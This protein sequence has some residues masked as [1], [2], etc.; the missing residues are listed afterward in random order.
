MAI[1]EIPTNFR[2]YYKSMK[3][4]IG[5]KYEKA[6]DDYEKGLV[7]EKALYDDIKLK[8]ETYKTVYKLDLTQIPEFVENKYIDGTFYDSAKELFLNRK[9][10]YIATNPAY[11]IYKLA[12]KQKELH[13]LKHQIEVYEKML[14]VTLDQ[15]Q[16]ILQAF[17][18]EVHKKLI[19]DGYGYVTGQSIE[20]GKDVSDNTVKITLS[21]KSN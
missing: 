4:A 16:K 21:Q 8:A 13:E 12:R 2:V 10:A 15:Y 18:N 17:Y 11:N 9:K 14:D 5:P 1:K 7:E 19:I 3:D 20:P 6:V